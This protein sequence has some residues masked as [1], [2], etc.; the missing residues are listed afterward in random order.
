LRSE[1]SIRSKLMDSQL[2]IKHGDGHG[3]RDV[4]KRVDIGNVGAEIHGLHVIFRYRLIW[5]CLCNAY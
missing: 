2:A 4:V 5:C 1:G 3:V